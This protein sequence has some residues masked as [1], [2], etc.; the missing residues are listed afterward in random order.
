MEKLHFTIVNYAL[1]YTLHPKLSDC[2]LYTLKYHIYHTLHPCV[3]F[4]L[5]L[6]KSC[7]M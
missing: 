3:I 1:D 2:T 5:Y 7:C 6:I 4:L